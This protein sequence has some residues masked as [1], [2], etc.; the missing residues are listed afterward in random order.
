MALSINQ[1]GYDVVSAEGE[2]ISVKTFT[3]STRIDFN[4]ATLHNAS[5]VMIFQIVIEEGEPSIQECL[6]CTVETL[7]PMLRTLAEGTYLPVNRILRP[8][9]T[10]QPPGDLREIARVA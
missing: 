9:Q 10:A 1:V 7:Q 3:S 6:D 5:R 8:K 4:L 2:R